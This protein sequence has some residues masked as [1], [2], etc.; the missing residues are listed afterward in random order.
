MMEEEVQ[1][2]AAV[3]VVAE[4]AEELHVNDIFICSISSFMISP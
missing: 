2:V 4:G 3:E 1:V